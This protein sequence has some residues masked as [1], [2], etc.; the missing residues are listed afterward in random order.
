MQNFRS[1]S[2]K[3]R[4]EYIQTDVTKSTQ[5]VTLIINILYILY[6]IFDV[7]SGSYKYHDKLNIPC[8]GYKKTK[9]M[10]QKDKISLYVKQNKAFSTLRSLS[11][12]PEG[13]T[14]ILRT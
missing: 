8:S 4:H 5:L 11:F 3:L 7:S 13:V 14:I 9:T 6:R 10:N 2:Q 12:I 1:I